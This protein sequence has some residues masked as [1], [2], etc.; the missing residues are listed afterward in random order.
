MF[1]VSHLSFRSTKKKTQE[2]FVVCE[3][4][5]S[6]ESDRLDQLKSNRMSFDLARFRS[7]INL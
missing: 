3:F 7:F 5:Q 4:P 2:Q 1:Q 6:L